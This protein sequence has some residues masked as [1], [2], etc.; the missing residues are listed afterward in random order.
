MAA[1]S[2]FGAD[3][4]LYG[5]FGDGGNANDVGDGHNPTTG[6]A[7]DLTTILGK[8]IRI[9]PLNPTLTTDA[10]GSLGKNGQYRIPPANPFLST[11]NALGEIYAYGFRNPYRFSF[12]AGTGRLVL[13]DVGQNNIEEV[14]IVVRGGNYGWHIQEGT[15]LFDATSGNVFTNPNP[16]PKLINPVAQ[17][18]H[19][20]ATVNAVTRGGFHTSPKCD[21]GG[22]IRSRSVNEG[23]LPKA[24]R[25]RF[26]VLSG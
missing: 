14:D 24:P 23:G 11:S 15:F 12:D 6:N 7:Q 21:E 13:G 8:M 20:E 25:S 26:R 2:A 16:N 1:R 4:L 18:D 22:F 9:N 5:A 10:D 17:Y 3:G 19:F